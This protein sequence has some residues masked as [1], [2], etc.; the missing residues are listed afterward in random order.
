MDSGSDNTRQTRRRSSLVRKFLRCGRPGIPL[1]VLVGVLI[2]FLGGTLTGVWIAG[3]EFA[4]DALQDLQD[5]LTRTIVSSTERAVEEHLAAPFVHLL[6]MESE[7]DPVYG[8]ASMNNSDYFS[9]FC[10]DVPG[11]GTPTSPFCSPQC[12]VDDVSCAPQAIFTLAQAC[13]V[14]VKQVSGF[15]M[16][17]RAGYFAG[18][19]CDDYT[20][21]NATYSLPLE[22][23]HMNGTR[24]DQNN[25]LRWYYDP[26]N[27]DFTL[28]NYSMVRNDYDIEERS[29]F[30]AASKTREFF[31]TKPYTCFT[32]GTDCVSGT[33]GIYSKSGEFE[34]AV[35]FDFSLETINTI[36]RDAWVSN[37]AGGLVI[38]NVTDS[39]VPANAS[40]TAWYSDA[41]RGKEIMEAVVAEVKYSMKE[42]EGEWSYRTAIDGSIYHIRV[43]HINPKLN[44]RT[45]N[46]VT[47][48]GEL[49]PLDWKL[50]VFLPRSYF[51]GTIDR[52]TQ[53]SL[54]V[55]LGVVVFALF[56]ITGA[57]TFGLIMPI[58]RLSMAMDEVSR[59]R[60]NNEKVAC[61]GSQKGILVHE[62][63]VMNAKFGVMVGLL[64]E[65]FTFLPEPV[66]AKFAGENPL[67]NP[68]ESSGFVS[69]RHSEASIM[70]GLKSFGLRKKLGTILCAECDVALLATSSSAIQFTEVSQ[71]LV[72]TL[73]RA[74]DEAGVVLSVMAEKIVITY[75]CQRNCSQHAEVACRC[76]LTASAKMGGTPRSYEG[77]SFVITSSQLWVGTVGTEAHRSPVVYGDAMLQAVS[78]GYL[79]K[80]INLRIMATGV[81]NDSLP[82]LHMRP[83]D[84]VALQTVSNIAHARVMEVHVFEV[85]DE[86]PQHSRG[87]LS[88]FAALHRMN[89]PEARAGFIKYLRTLNSRDHQAV[90]L[91]QLTL[92]LESLEVRDKHYCRQL[93]GW[94]DFE[95]QISEDQLPSE[96]LRMMERWEA[97]Q[98]SIREASLTAV[99][100]PKEEKYQSSEGSRTT[101]STVATH[102][103]DGVR[104]PISFKDPESAS[105]Y[106]R[107]N[108]VLGRG[109]YGTVYLSM[110][111]EGHLVAMK[112]IKLPQ[113]PEDLPG[114]L[115]GT[116]QPL[117]D[118]CFSAVEAHIET[119]RL[120]AKLLSDIAHENIVSYISSGELDGWLIIVM[121]YMSQGSLSTILKDFRQKNRGVPDESARRYILQVLNALKDL[122]S[123]L[124]VHCDIKPDNVLLST[125]GVCK[126]ID[127][128]SAKR[129]GEP[130]DYTRARGSPM[131][132]SPEACRRQIHTASDIWS[133]G[134]MLC[135]LITGELPWTLSPSDAD[136][137]ERVMF[138][139]EQGMLT[140]HFG[141]PIVVS[142]C[143]DFVTNC[144]DRDPNKRPTAS[145]LL[146]DSFIL[147]QP[148]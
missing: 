64:K 69:L 91:I 133:L 41:P 125:D 109:G 107:S 82:R 106:T 54:Y 74:K 102:G 68:S 77:T 38:L 88:A 139:M 147:D 104:A 73:L 79:A 26:M 46:L 90:R 53:I 31:F 42:E 19:M 13:R 100:K 24:D 45:I 61:I 129:V 76:A 75:N 140:P 119:I 40:Y 47:D 95:S 11:T 117:A 121:E 99:Q 9:P 25:L 67:D 49:Q 33:Y 118:L 108:R 145:E 4:V 7:F 86:S 131:Y 8:G 148:D 85:L 1:W 39:S 6:S 3:K 97:P 126:L 122:H 56:V 115:P 17:S 110:S 59:I 37:R 16:G 50:V 135:E 123:N 57:T 55:F 12:V 143:K 14:R 116:G 66:A 80:V 23:S 93:P 32:T 30:A 111:S 43:V 138:L 58:R 51:F 96:V 78:L 29:W 20:D 128:G 105:F 70:S 124:V 87:Y 81:I 52:Y 101:L 84:I 22:V 21:E 5:A 113:S 136:K 130:V 34:G 103:R 144:L 2:L 10:T 35:E 132:M 89:L 48:T 27:K 36:L 146:L 15:F 62:I 141:A 28:F 112:T 83:V 92:A 98:H 18:V 65:W 142:K 72:S 127:F 71:K 44:N 120:E 137:P 134:V 60:F 114:A 63:L 94:V